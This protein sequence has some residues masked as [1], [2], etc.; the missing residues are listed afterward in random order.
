M[1]ETVHFTAVT[2]NGV[3]KRSENREDEGNCDQD[4]EGVHVILIDCLCEPAHDKIIYKDTDPGT[5]HGIYN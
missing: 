4:T 3:E 1:T 2:E 5:S